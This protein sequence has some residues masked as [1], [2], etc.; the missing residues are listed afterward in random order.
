MPFTAWEKA[1]QYVK[2]IKL[3]RQAH[4]GTQPPRQKCRCHGCSEA[5]GAKLA[6]LLLLICCIVLVTFTFDVRNLEGVFLWVKENK[7]Q[8][9]LLFL[10]SPYSVLPC[11]SSPPQPVRGFN[12][13]Y[14]M[15]AIYTVALVLMVPAMV[16]SMCSGAIFGL[17]AGTVIV[18]LGSAVGQVMAF[19][20][21]R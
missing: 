19:I 15:Q 11:N 20:V 7:L 13:K 1:L 9:S 3:H 12:K 8:G 2:F 16:M 14:S 4:I 18:W 17:L 6:V 21:G 5:C 10:V